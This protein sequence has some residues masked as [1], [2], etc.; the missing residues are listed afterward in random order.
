MKAIAK[1]KNPAIIMHT[2]KIL[3][4]FWLFINFGFGSGFSGPIVCE[5]QM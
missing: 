2:M 3:K 1:E 5:K 4:N